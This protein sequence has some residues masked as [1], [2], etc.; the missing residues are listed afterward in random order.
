MA[1]SQ[2]T[3]P[4]GDR[5]HVPTDQAAPE[6]CDGCGQPTDS[7]CWTDCGMSLCA[8]PLCGDCIHIDEKFG[9][10]HEPRAKGG[11]A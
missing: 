7:M 10:R 4:A 6:L 5:Q 2:I 1:N 3:P 9:W 8:T 11:A